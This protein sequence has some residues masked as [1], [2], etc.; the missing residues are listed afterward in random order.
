[1]GIVKWKICGGNLMK[2]NNF[3]NDEFPD[4]EQSKSADEVLHINQN[5]S[6]YEAQDIPVEKRVQVADYILWSLLHETIEP[7]IKDKMEHLLGQLQELQAT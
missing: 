5:L 4:G 6:T 1:M 2:T 3:W 7:N